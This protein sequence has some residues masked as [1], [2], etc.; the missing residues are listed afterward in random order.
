MTDKLIEAVAHAIRHHFS[1]ADKAYGEHVQCAKDA[2]AAIEA[3]GTHV[4]AP[5]DLT[6]EMAAALR[7]PM[8]VQDGYSAILAARPRVVLP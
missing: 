2:I 4:V 3:S 7:Y 6:R 1:G 5:L 8:S